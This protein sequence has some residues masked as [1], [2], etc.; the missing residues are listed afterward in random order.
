MVR[1]TKTKRFRRFSGGDIPVHKRSYA[2]LGT[3]QII[4]TDKNRQ[5][6]KTMKKLDLAGK[7]N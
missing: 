5:T 4:V 3:G 1:G 2:R 7:L 6:Y